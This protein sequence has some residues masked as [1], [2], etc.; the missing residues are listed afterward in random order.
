M[1]M[2]AFFYSKSC[3]PLP[4]YFENPCFY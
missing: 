4:N 1:L 3:Q 2:I